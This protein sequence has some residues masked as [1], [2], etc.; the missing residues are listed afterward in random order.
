M[1]VTNAPLRSQK[2]AA[3]VSEVRGV[4][5]SLES[6]FVDSPFRAAYTEIMGSVDRKTAKTKF[7]AFFEQKNLRMTAQRM[8][9]IDTVF[10]TDQHFTAE[11]LLEWSRKRDKSVSRAT[12]YRTLPLLTESGLVQE[13]DFGKAY[14]YYDPNYADHPRH[15]HIVCQDCD[16]I[17]E[18]ESE[19]IEMLESKISEKLGFPPKSPPNHIT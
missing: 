6:P 18:L 19:K 16:K 13:L 15:N 8:A 3:N 9:I 11:E 12:V 5:I 14:K 17:V 7:I 10:G 1:L 4:S 2:R